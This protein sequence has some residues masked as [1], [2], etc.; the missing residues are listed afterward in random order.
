M[1]WGIPSD[2]GGNT[3]V[4]YDLQRRQGGD[5]GWT[6]VANA[7]TYGSGTL[8]YELDY[9]PDGETYEVRVRADSVVTADSCAAMVDL[10]QGT[11][12]ANQA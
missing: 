5:S 8:S 12:E 3:I 6:T 7:W 2:V 1:Y 9:L 10:G 4:A 11:T